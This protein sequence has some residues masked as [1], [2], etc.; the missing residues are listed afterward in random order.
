MQKPLDPLE[1][2]K[3][4]NGHWR[5]AFHSQKSRK[6]LAK[7]PF[8]FKK[9]P[10]KIRLNPFVLKKSRT[11][12]PMSEVPLGH[13]YNVSYVLSTYRVSY[14]FLKDSIPVFMFTIRALSSLRYRG[15]R[16]K[17]DSKSP[18]RTITNCFFRRITIARRKDYIWSPPRLNTRP[19]AFSN[20]HQRCPLIYRKLQNHYVCCM[21]FFLLGVDLCTIDSILPAG[22]LMLVVWWGWA[23]CAGF[24]GTSV[25]I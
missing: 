4:R 20:S 24:G 18:Y 17:V 25:S 9:N 6:P 7:N 3:G 14:Q 15:C 5:G 2:M 21:L 1:N 16:A 8:V 13:W 12:F 11:L 23:V 10:S 19:F 22:A